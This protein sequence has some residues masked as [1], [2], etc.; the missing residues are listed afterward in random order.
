M[1]YIQAVVEG[2]SGGNRQQPEQQGRGG[3]GARVDA[4]LPVVPGSTVKVYVG[5]RG[6]QA[7]GKLNQEKATGAWYGGGGGGGSSAIVV[8]GEVLVI[9]AGGGGAGAQGYDEQPGD[10]G[11]GAAGG[12]PR[13]CLPEQA[14]AGAVQEETEDL[15]SQVRAKAWMTSVTGI[16]CRWS[17]TSWGT[18]RT[19][20]RSCLLSHW[21]T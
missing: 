17:L 2:G 1:N 4:M 6:A 19:R 10:G 11:S 20:L 18:A 3:G 9:A 13:T 21:S 14:E 8:D 12:T 16:W 7:T 5:D 15:I